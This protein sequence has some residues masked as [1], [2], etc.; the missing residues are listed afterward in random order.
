MTVQELKKWLN[1]KSED[2]EVRTDVYVHNKRREVVI[3]NEFD[4]SGKVKSSDLTVYLE[5]KED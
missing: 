3:V 2:A 1:T 4:D 5:D